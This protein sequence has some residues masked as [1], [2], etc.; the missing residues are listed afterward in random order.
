MEKRDA[1]P[2]EYYRMLHPFFYVWDIGAGNAGSEGLQ[3]KMRKG[4]RPDD[5]K[6]AEQKNSFPGRRSLA[7]SAFVRKSGT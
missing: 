7:R 6:C 1:A 2:A 4:S 3:I 5:V